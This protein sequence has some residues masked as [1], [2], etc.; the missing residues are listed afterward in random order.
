MWVHGSNGVVLLRHRVEQMGSV[1]S[2]NL[3]RKRTTPQI[4]LLQ[5]ARIHVILEYEQTLD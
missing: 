1:S 4:P 2:C 3:T 5:G